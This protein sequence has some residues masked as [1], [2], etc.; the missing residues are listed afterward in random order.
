MKY[1]ISIRQFIFLF[2]FTTITPLFTYISQISARN[3]QNSGYISALYFGAVLFVFAALL[4]RIAKIYSGQNLFEILCQL[5]GCAVTRFLFFLYGIFVFLLLLYKLSTYNLL[6][7][8]TLMN[9]TNNY[10][11]LSGLFFLVLYGAFQG[12]KTIFRVSELL[13]GPLLFFLILLLIFTLPNINK[14]YLAPVTTAQLVKNLPTLWNFAPIGG[15]LFF[16]SLFPVS[17]NQQEPVS[18]HKKIPISRRICIHYHQLFMHFSNHR[19]CRCYPNQPIQ[20]PL[21]PGY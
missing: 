7:Q 2:L 15:N 18:G 1:Q 8:T 12:V 6:I 14:D 4:L 16:S 20:L 21:I 5:I 19:N 17:N 10:I 11:I 3:A 13:Y 9:S